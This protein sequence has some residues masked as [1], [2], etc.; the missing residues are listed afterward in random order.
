MFLL[1][2]FVNWI[3]T[4]KSSVVLETLSF[5]SLFAL[6]L[7]YH[8]KI[9]GL[10]LSTLNSL[11][12]RIF[13]IDCSSSEALV[14]IRLATGSIRLF[15]DDLLYV[16]FLF[17]VPGYLVDFKGGIPSAFEF[18]N[19]LSVSLFAIVKVPVRRKRI[20]SFLA[21]F[22]MICTCF[23]VSGVLHIRADLLND[24]KFP[25]FIGVLIAGI[26][27]VYVFIGMCV[28][29]LL[30]VVVSAFAFFYDGFI[31]TGAVS[32]IN[33]EAVFGSLDSACSVSSIRIISLHSLSVALF[34]YLLVEG[35]FLHC[36]SS[37]FVDRGFVFTTSVCS[38]LFDDQFAGV[39]KKTTKVLDII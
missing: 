21:F 24:V 17:Q 10:E 2:Y 19:F 15:F 20:G 34:S 32:L 5:H 3:L 13:I 33:F 37:S 7:V 12:F 18:Y 1:E 31:F 23:G 4:Y 38:P 39:V 36:F 35:V 26:F 11:V 22:F 25:M 14:F 30:V 16:C 27:A 28:V 6:W 29:E 9:C 8:L